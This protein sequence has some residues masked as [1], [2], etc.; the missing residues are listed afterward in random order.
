METVNAKVSKETPESQ[1]SRKK[2]LVKA[3][4][5]V[6][7]AII[8]YFSYE[9]FFFVSTDNAQ[10]LGKTVM[11]APKVSGY[12]TKV[13]VEENQRVKA[14]EVLAEV[15]SRDFRNT[16]K[17]FESQAGGIEVRLKD[18][19]RNYHRL[20]TLLKSGS[21]SQ[22]QFET[23]QASYL[24][25]TRQLQ[26]L[27]AQI[28]QVKLNLENTQIKAPSDGVVARKAAE[29]GM[30]AATG[31]PLFGFVS[32]ESRWVSA[33]FKETELHS[34]QVGKKVL[35]TVD[36]L[37]GTTY[38]GTVESLSPSTGATFTLL[39]PDNA[40][41]NFTKVVQRVP[42]RI[43]LEK[44]TAQD[45]DALQSGLSAYVKVRIR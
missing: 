8:G 12:V 7:L 16:L 29:V 40:S 30:Y 18:L 1:G 14:G 38:D 9:A 37:P 21:V 22:Q 32:S 25:S 24:E 5:A 17:Q 15:D 13:E 43:R 35:V 39:P 27:Q 10:V 34:I 4:P 23:A 31:T 42:V 6:F 28:D 11:L 36:A 19:E 20:S 41:G 3:V 45:I 44:L 33:N 2:L 26:A